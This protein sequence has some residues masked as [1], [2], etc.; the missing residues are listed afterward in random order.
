MKILQTNKSK[1]IAMLTIVILALFSI[2]ISAQDKEKPKSKLDKL[3]GKVEKITVKVDGKDVVFDGKEAEKLAKQLSEQKRIVIRTD[4]G[5]EMM[6]ACD[7]DEMMSECDG[8]AVM[9]RKIDRNKNYNFILNKGEENKKI[10]VEDKDGAKTVTVTTTKDGKEETKTYKGEDAEKFLKEEKGKEHF[11]FFIGDDEN[12]PHSRF[13]TF[14]HKDDDEGC[15]CCR[16][17]RMMMRRHLPGKTMHM[18]IK[19]FDDD[20]KSKEEKPEKK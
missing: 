10:N 6:S 8:A 7:G 3:K 11:K 19:D 17:N 18:I 4:D 16:G 1:F 12:M 9:L 15:C 13:M 5:D 2:A 20:D 14:N